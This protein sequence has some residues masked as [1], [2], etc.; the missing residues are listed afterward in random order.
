MSG[1]RYTEEF[2]IE[3]IKQVIERGYKAVA[4]R[5]AVLGF[6]MG[7]NDPHGRRHLRC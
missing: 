5:A 1:K 6:C 7:Q 4:V 2:K 3:A